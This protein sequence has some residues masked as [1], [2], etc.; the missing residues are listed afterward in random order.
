ML[1]FKKSVHETSKHGCLRIH[2]KS[3][4]VSIILFLLSSWKSVWS[5]LEGT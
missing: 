4:L 5:Y 3:S 2:S 1:E